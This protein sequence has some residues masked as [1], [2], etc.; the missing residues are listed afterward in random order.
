MLASAGVGGQV[1]LWEAPL[2]SKAAP[3]L[4]V[5]QRLDLGESGR[6]ILSVS[7]DREGCLLAAAGDGGSVKIAKVTPVDA[8]AVAVED[9]ILP[10]TR[11]EFQAAD[12]ALMGITL[13]EI[14]VMIK[15]LDDNSPAGV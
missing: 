4:E 2:H 3:Q 9:V 14:E 13:N 12:A 1:L 6:D 8:M 7:W 5:T 10:F 11:K 15:I